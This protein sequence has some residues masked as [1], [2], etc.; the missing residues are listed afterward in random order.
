MAYKSIACSIPFQLDNPWNHLSKVTDVFATLFFVDCGPKL[1]NSIEK[2]IK[3]T[4]LDSSMNVFFE[5]MPE[6]F[7]RV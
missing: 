3:V 2:F 7:Y 6:V 4:G 5:L 1:F